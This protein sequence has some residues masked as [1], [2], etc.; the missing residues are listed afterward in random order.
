MKCLEVSLLHIEHMET[1]GNKMNN[2]E[3]NMT[4]HLVIKYGLMLML[5]IVIG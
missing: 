5:F 3:D 2:L 4:K 1:L